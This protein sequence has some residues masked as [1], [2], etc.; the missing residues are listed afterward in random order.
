MGHMKTKTPRE[1]IYLHAW[2]VAT[3]AS[4]A[5]LKKLYKAYGSFERAWQM[6]KQNI[7]PLEE[8]KKFQTSYPQLRLISYRDQDYPPLLKQLLRAP[9]SLYIQG[10]FDTSLIGTHALLSVVGTR[11]PSP[12]GQLQTQRMVQYLAPY[13]V[14]IISG[15]AD[16]VDS[17]AHETALLESL[18]TWAVIGHGHAY[19]RETKA[20]LAQQILKNGCIISEYPPETPPERFRFPERN[21]IIAGL[22]TVTVVTEAPQ[23]SGANITAKIAR[24]ENRD[25]FA[26]TSDIDRFECQ[27]NLDLIEQNIATPLTSYS[28]LL[29]AL[30]LQETTRLQRKAEYFTFKDPVLNA[31]AEALDYK[32]PTTITEI[33]QRG[34][35]RDISLILEKLT[36]LE[37]DGFVESI[38]GG[39]RL[40]LRR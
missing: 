36:I 14:I 23:K 31:L 34:K 13:R 1:T 17:L 20:D 25:V 12:Y 26:I 33:M 22:S 9:L 19:L 7:D 5:T 38:G 4:Y 39:Y 27:G 16:G 3:H 6:C 40:K 35:I 15:L 11:R 18:P 24:E 37:I 2:N 32:H 30:N 8:W 10:N 28:M 21:R 29:H